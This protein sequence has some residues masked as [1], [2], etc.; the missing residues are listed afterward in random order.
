MRNY[1]RKSSYSIVFCLV[2]LLLYD[3]KSKILGLRETL[4]SIS[5]LTFYSSKL[6]KKVVDKFRQSK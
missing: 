2:S 1:L 3:S 6:I 5:F 4:I